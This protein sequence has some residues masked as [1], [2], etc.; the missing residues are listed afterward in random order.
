[1]NEFY[2]DRFAKGKIDI[3]Y[4]SKMMNRHGIIAGATGTGKTIT[5]KVLAESFSSHGVPVFLADIKGDLASVALQ[6]M[7]NPKLDERIKMLGLEPFSYTSYPTR[8]WDLFGEKGHPIRTTISEM[9]PLLI[10][11]LL[12]LNE[13]QSGVLNI[14]FKIADDE[15]YLLIDLKD[16]RSMLNYVGEHSSDYTTAYGTISKVTIGTI[17]RGLLTLESQGAEQFFGEPALDIRDFFNTDSDGRGFINVLSSDKL[18][19]SPQLYSTFL[20]WLLSELFEVLPEVGDLDKPKLVFFFDEA[21]LLFDDAPKALVDKIEQVVRLIRS[22][23]VGVFFVTQNPADIPDR[24]LAQ[25]GNRVQHALRAYTPHEQKG[26]QAAAD[27]FRVN[28]ELDTLTALTELKTGE[29]LV[30]MLDE[31]GR[32]AIVQRAFVF[33]PHSLLGAIDDASRAKLIRDSKFDAIYRKTFDRES[34]YEL[35][36]KRV[37]REMEEVADEEAR[38]QRAKEV[39][40]TSRTTTTRRAPARRATG[41]EKA[42]NSMMTSIGR[43]VGRELI[44]GIFG[45]LIK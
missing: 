32:P 44:R 5:L 15:G 35:I 17:Q 1:M 9:G 6:G 31:D 10:A 29:A 40:Q 33:P 2:A 16:L 30:S 20:L 41:L 8:C 14:V 24:I 43:S 42:A 37:K 27:S 3:T 13:T 18:F 36:T 12:Q 4:A 45:S 26:L 39:R 28:P 23:G 22:K 19:Q 11:R 34:A 25:L 38:T 21:H 7:G